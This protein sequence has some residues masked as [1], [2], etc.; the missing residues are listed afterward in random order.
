MLDVSMILRL[1]VPGPGAQ[2]SKNQRLRESVFIHTQQCTHV[3]H[4]CKNYNLCTHPVFDKYKV[5][6]I[7]QCNYQLP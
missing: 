7:H 1:V 6:L 3:M 5:N 4:I 2:D